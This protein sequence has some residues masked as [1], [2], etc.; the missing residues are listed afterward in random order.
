MERYTPP[1]TTNAG[2]IV[3]ETIFLNPVPFVK[4]WYIPIKTGVGDVTV[5][6]KEVLLPNMTMMKIDKIN[7]LPKSCKKR[8]ATKVGAQRISNEDIDDLLEEIH[9]KD[10]LNTEFDIEYD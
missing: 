3:Y 4:Y 7:T 8:R 1:I 6:L 9:I 10:K 5:R 2:E